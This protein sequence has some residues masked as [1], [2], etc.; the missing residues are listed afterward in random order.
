MSEATAVA[1]R[2]STKTTKANSIGALVIIVNSFGFDAVRV[3]VRCS[4]YKLGS[5]KLQQSHCVFGMPDANGWVAMRA[6][7][8]RRDAMV[9]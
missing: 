2:T 3:V 4:K 8:W 7:V 6:L 5:I 9:A 1:T